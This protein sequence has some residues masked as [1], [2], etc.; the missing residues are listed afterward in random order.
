MDA[1]RFGEDGSALAGRLRAGTG[2]VAAFVEGRTDDTKIEELLFAFSLVDWR[3][4][5]GAGRRAAGGEIVGRE[6]ALLKLL[7]C[8][9]GVEGADGQPLRT[10]PSIVALLEAQRVADACEVAKRRLQAGGLSPLRVRYENGGDG[11][12]LAGALLIPV[13]GIQGLKRLVLRME[14]KES[15]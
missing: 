6:Y 9:V 7:F 1:A 11:Q 14:E 10:E 13:T 15:Q 2:D 3:R 8:D 4:G 5:N 12:R